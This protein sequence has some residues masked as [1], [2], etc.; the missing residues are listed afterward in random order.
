MPSASRHLQLVLWLSMQPRGIRVHS[1]AACPAGGGQRDPAA[2]GGIATQRAALASSG[3]AP[4][5]TH[6]VRAVLS[7]DADVPCRSG[8]VL[9][10]A[11]SRPSR[12]DVGLD[13]EHDA[14]V[15][16]VVAQRAGE[17]FDQRLAV[18]RR[19]RADRARQRR[20]GRLAAKQFHR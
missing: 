4:N 1:Q 15:V 9:G 2:V 18:G 12:R 7:P 14:I 11:S 19:Q 17:V 6:T 20:S 5:A 16:G 8:A 13:R 10:E 3:A